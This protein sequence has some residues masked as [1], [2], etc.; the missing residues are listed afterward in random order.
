MEISQLENIIKMLNSPDEE[1]HVVALSVLEQQSFKKCFVQ[2]AI[3]YK[4]GKPKY[5]LWKL[6]CPKAFKYLQKILNLK[7]SPYGEEKPLTF[8]DI[9]NVIIEHKMEPIQLTIFME[10]FS[11]FL[12]KQCKSLGYNFVDSIEVNVKFK[13]KENVYT[14]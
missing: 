8:N 7:D 10:M 1:N 12:T 11:K 13:I 3:A 5:K 6:H 14:E 4:F 2:L 9:F